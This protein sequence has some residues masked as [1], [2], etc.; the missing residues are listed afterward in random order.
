MSKKEKNKVDMLNY[1]AQGNV[2]PA[3]PVGKGAKRDAK[4]S[5]VGFSI[6]AVILQ[7]LAFVP[8][9]ACT[10]PLALKGYGLAPNYTIWH[11]VGTI[12]AGLFGL[13]FM[14]IALVVQR[15][16]SKSSVRTQTVK[17][18]ITFICLT[19]VFGLVL[20]YGLPDIVNSLTQTTLRMEDLYYLSESQM[21][22]NLSLER[23]FIRENILNG[24]LADHKYAYSDMEAHQEENG[25]IVSYDNEF[26]DKKWK[27][28]KEMSVEGL[29]AL[30]ESMQK[31]QFKY[32]LYECI[33]QSYILTDYD[34]AFK[35]KLDTGISDSRERKALAVAMVDYIYQ[36]TLY[37]DYLE[38]GFGNPVLDGLLGNEYS[39]V[40]KLF[41]ANWDNLTQ[42]GYNT[43]DDPL[44]FYA[45]MSSRMTVPVVVRLLLDD[46]WTYTQPV[47]GSDGTKYYKEDGNYLFEMYDS[48][49]WAAY[50][51]I[52]DGK[53]DD[54]KYPYSG[55]LFN[56]KAMN[57]GYYNN[58]SDPDD[59]YNG[60]MIFAD[61]TVK[62]PVKWCVLD[63]DGNVMSVAK[64]DITNLS[65]AGLDL[66]GLITTALDSFPEIV[67]ALGSLLTDDVAGLLRYATNGAVLGVSLFINDSGQLEINILPNNI[68]FGV[69]GYMKHS[70]VQSNGLLMAV[71]GL[72][73]LRNYLYIF[74]AVGAILIVASGALRECGKKTRERGEIAKDRV[75]RAKAAKKHKE[76]Q[77]EAQAE[78]EAPATA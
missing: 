17:L 11:F 77:S 16:K 2:I 33:Y 36:D 13:I 42:D 48:T 65:V 57:Y 49:A 3:F 70:W 9:I 23:I 6:A 39:E 40:K 55:T 18:L 21:E 61:G 19:C 52:M 59:L 32:E 44:L 75:L 45:Q 25:T 72:A 4:K 47:Y 62:R 71:F 56:G 5:S 29:D 35:W 27:E 60:W 38:E 78:G 22:T 46:T 74:G 1:D 41:D 12:V 58:P 64:L 7:I 14:V 37:E 43:F 8:I 34:Y 28:Y 54:E 24:T 63:M 50:E 76:S 31:D 20:S 66:G 68:T 30:I 26:I 10:I 53:S 67:D 73:S 69:L 15:K 51:A